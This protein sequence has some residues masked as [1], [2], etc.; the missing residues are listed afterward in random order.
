MAFA[1]VIALSS[2]GATGYRIIEG[3]TWAD[4]FYMV[5]IT[6]S[7][8]GF[9][10]V[11]PLSTEGRVWTI[12]LVV[13]GV[14]TLGFLAG[15]AI[16]LVTEGSLHGYRRRRRME[17]RIQSITGHYII[18]GYGRVGRQV[19]ADF[20]AAR[21]PFVVIDREDSTGE[22][23][24]RN[25]PHLMG[26]AEEESVL[27]A[28]GI[29]RAAGLVAAVDS[30]TENVFITLTAKVLNPSLRVIARA[31]NAETAR[32]LELVG[33]ERVVSPYVASGKRMAHMALR[34]HAV[35]F[36]DLVSTPLQE[37]SVE[38][39]ELE[40]SA[41]GGLAGRSLRELDLRRST[42]IIVVA[43]RNEDKVQLNPDPD[44]VLKPGGRM[45]VLG[46]SEQCGR[47]QELNR[48]RPD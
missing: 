4:C 17:S 2:A 24:A 34:P 32:K 28:A 8:V 25:I 29:E 33:A 14:G 12:L 48:G 41:E 46:T 21:R 11:H 39:Q 27:R 37:L 3:W 43:L 16:E 20:E 44:A 42:G 18:C 22:L 19:V 23:R 45:T 30:D 26:N 13:V 10:E 35:D 31:S 38:M 7:T 47:L 40:I 6:L 1:V 5:F 9:S 15:R 36:F